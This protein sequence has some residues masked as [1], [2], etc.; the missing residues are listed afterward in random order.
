MAT[1]NGE[2]TASTKKR[3]KQNNSKNSGGRG[4]RL[5]R[6]RNDVA[7]HPRELVVDE[8][9]GELPLIAPA[10]RPLEPVDVV[11]AV[12]VKNIREERRAECVAHLV[13]RHPGLELR[14]HLLGDV[15]ALLDVDRVGRNARNARHVA[16][17]GEQRG[18]QERGNAGSEAVHGQY[19]D[20][21]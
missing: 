21:R 17:T 1:I 19:N 18:E 2:T 8:V 5:G 4:F 9:H 3:N 14:H 16:A 15:V 12:A 10:V 7:G 6:R 20:S 11:P 13:L